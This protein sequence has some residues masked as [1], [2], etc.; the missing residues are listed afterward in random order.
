MGIALPEPAALWQHIPIPRR[1]YADPHANRMLAPC[2]PYA[3]PM[4]PALT[5]AAN[6]HALSPCFTGCRQKGVAG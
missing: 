3:S 5:V 1:T 6:R 2:R 4:P